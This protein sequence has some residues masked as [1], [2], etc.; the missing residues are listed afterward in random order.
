MRTYFRDKQAHIRA[1]VY[2][3]WLTRHRDET[4]WRD[5]GAVVVFECARF[6]LSD[7][8]YHPDKRRYEVL[9]VT[10]PDEYH[11]RVHNNAFTNRMAAHTLEICLAV[12]DLLR[13]APRIS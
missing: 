10:G 12:A 4:I 5:G 7:I 6:F 9:D 1:G 2:A 11:E 3:F 8:Y 13:A